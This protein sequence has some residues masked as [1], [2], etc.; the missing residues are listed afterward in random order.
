MWL[1]T[2]LIVISV[3]TTKQHYLVDIVGGIVLVVPFIM[4]LKKWSNLK[5]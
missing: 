4:I 1:W 5:P 3:L 2:A